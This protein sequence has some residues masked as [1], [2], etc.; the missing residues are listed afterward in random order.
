MIFMMLPNI[1]LVGVSF[2]KGASGG[3][4]FQ[5]TLENYIRA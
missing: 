3:L 1:L 2:L 4:V 5:P